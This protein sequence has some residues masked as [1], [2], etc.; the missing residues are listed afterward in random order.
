M[1]ISGIKTT[2]T[3][4]KVPEYHLRAP[5]AFEEMQAISQAERIRAALNSLRQPRSVADGIKDE[6]A[7]TSRCYGI[8]E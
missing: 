5:S 8:L 7:S 4:E 3:Y 6:D 1:F 2:V